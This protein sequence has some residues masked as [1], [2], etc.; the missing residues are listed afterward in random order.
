[1]ETVMEGEVSKMGTTQRRARGRPAEYRDRE[2]V[3]LLLQ[4]W[5]EREQM[6]AKRLVYQLESWLL[7]FEARYGRLEE[8]LRLRFLDVSAATIDRLLGP[9]RRGRFGTVS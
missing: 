4:C 5:L 3:S 2:F 6:C 7:E 8:D 1:M 9:V